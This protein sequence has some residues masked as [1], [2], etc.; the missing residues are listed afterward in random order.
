[1]TPA[2]DAKSCCSISSDDEQAL[3]LLAAIG[4]DPA[5]ILAPN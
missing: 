1:M 4:A 2:S 3:A 5:V